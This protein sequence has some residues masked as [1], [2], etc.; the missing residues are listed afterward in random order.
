M[1]DNGPVTQREHALPPGENLVSTTDLKGRIV[2]CNAAFVAASGFSR[3]ELEGQPHNLIR[4]PDMPEA[5]FRDMWETIA[6]GE[7]WSMLVKNR[8][9]D[10][11]H[12]WVRANVTPLV[13][14]D[15]V[16]GYMSVRTVAARAA[17]DSA[18][19]LYAR[20]RHEEVNGLPPSMRLH[21]GELQRCG[22]AG[23]WQAATRW[24][25][26][27]RLALLPLAAAWAAC[28]FIAIAGFTVAAL[29]ATPLALGSFW[30]QRRAL[31]APLGGLLRFAQRMAAG[32]L[33]QRLDVTRTDL[34][35]RLQQSLNQLNVNLQTVVGDARAEVEHM[36]SGVADI[37]AGNRD[38][39]ARTESQAASLQQTAA[40]IEEIT[41]AVRV[42]ASS[43]RES[44]Q[45]AERAVDITQ[46][47]Q[48][49]VD[50][51]RAT[52]HA[53]SESSR[54]IGKALSNVPYP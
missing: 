22:W 48:A 51:L 43:A 52:M 14:G 30:L 26:R 18:A 23:R 7:P 6:A 49:N 5:A 2:Y 8:R 4:H 11:D 1:R 45:L 9:K 53:I 32:D 39:S 29:L 21:R 50:S 12:Y 27:Q 17:I 10:G 13:E 24:L 38:M 3:A 37:A 47:S 41:G 31:Q 28:V 36:Q 44:A 33:T 35:G 46:R 40:S 42:N 15:R 20:L 16:V 25:A 34:A 19:A 54:N